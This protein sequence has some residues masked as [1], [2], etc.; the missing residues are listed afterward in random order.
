MREEALASP[1]TNLL[2]GFAFVVLVVFFDH[3]SP[4]E[5]SFSLFYLVPV[6]WVTWF[7]GRRLGLVT[8][9]LSTVTWLFAN[10]LAGVTYPYLFA[11]LWELGT[12][13]CAFTAILL[14]A[15]TV[16]R[17]LRQVEEVSVKDA[18]TGVLNTR[19]FRLLAE[20]EVARTQR[21]GTALTVAYIDADNFKTL[22]DQR[23]HREGDKALK[24]MAS[25]MAANVRQSDAV[26][27]LG[28]DEFVVLLPKA[29][30][31]EAHWVVAR[32][33]HALLKAMEERGYPITFSIGIATFYTPP[34]S[35]NTMCE[36]ADRLMY[37]V[38]HHRKDGVLHEVYDGATMGSMAASVLD[39]PTPTVLRLM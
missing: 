28:G 24:L 37:Q 1:L 7:C 38:K 35:A 34:A 30:E 23:G 29:D 18:L 9:A 12:K 8:V 2:V 39:M 14:F 10:A 6:I 5:I 27:R 22:N 33:R 21:E 4:A 11:F 26:A 13:V 19:G 31:R 20:T 25:I 15:D 16:N 3:V 17:R 32:T 36:T